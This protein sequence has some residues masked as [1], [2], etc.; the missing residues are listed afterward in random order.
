[1]TDVKVVL[2]AHEVPVYAQ[3]HAYLTNKL[4]GFFREL[5]G[6]QV[7]IEDPTDLVPLLGDRAYDLLC[8]AI[9][10]YG[11]RCPKHEFC[12]YASADA[13]ATLDYDE[14]ADQSPSFPEILNAFT[15]AAEVNRFDILKTIGKVVDP[16]L[17]RSWINTQLAV[18]IS[19]ASPSSPALVDG[20]ATS[21]DSGA[22][23]LT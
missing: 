18:A 17:L 1:M 2:G 3:R 23:T 11:K 21:T 12:G 8:V 19:N 20:S 5:S 4:A 6:L 15:V 10:A 14:D 7:D 9:P 13:H 22:T 16:K